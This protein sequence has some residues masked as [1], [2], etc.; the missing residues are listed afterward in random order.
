LR[1]RNYRLWVSGTIVSNTGTWM[2]R[3]AQDWLVLT[4]LTHHSGLAAGITTGLQFAP[5]L[6][7]SAHAGVLA[8]R[9]PKRAVLMCTQTVMG[10][11]A[12]TL[13]LLVVTDAVKLWEVFV[14]AFGLGL[15]AAFD[16]PARQAFASEVVP[17]QDVTSAISM[18][19]ASM[20]IARLVGP[21]VA[22]V[23]IA[24]FGTGPAF[25]LNAASFVAVLAALIRMRPA[26]MFIS[27]RLPRGRGQV[28]EGLR[29]VRSRPDLL[30]VFFIAGL[31]GTFGLN[32]QITNALMATGAFHVGAREYG[33]LGS[34]MAIGS[35][36]AALLA[37][38]RDR[39][40]LRLLLSAGLAFG[41][42]LTVAGL[43]PTFVL[44]AVMLIP[45]GLCSITLM[46]SCNTAVQMS[47]PQ[48][49]RGRVIA[50]YVIVF[51]GTTPIGAPIVGWLGSEFGA[52][53]SVLVGGI[54]ALLAVLVSMA[55]LARR[56]AIGAGFAAALREQ[57]EKNAEPERAASPADGSSA[58]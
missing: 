32:F 9:L 39:P 37:G 52:R 19:S 44:Y 10:L 3:T 26:E 53:W 7:L 11:S 16:N 42:C 6:L 13:G 45:V 55:V 49:L 17:R 36:S 41:V 12:L 4:V 14:C 38:S 47:T 18:N 28:L 54:A 25:L 29:Y 31:V 43:M 56:P 21:G 35:L 51:Q 50:L 15:A 58:A 34:V 24:D 20:N 40:R 23:L 22:G 48:H 46:N 57:A 33:L 8:D 30:L 5:L 2:Q 27:E 1:R